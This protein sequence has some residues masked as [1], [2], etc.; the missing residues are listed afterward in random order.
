[1]KVGRSSK[2]GNGWRSSDLR[3]RK[4][5]IGINSKSTHFPRHHPRV[6]ISANVS[7]YINQ[8]GFDMEL[9]LLFPSVWRS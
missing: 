6:W 9:T 1:M 8:S 4:G 7:G 3:K 2:S 5:D